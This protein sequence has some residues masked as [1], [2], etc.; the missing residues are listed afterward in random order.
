MG[1]YQADQPAP[2]G[3]RGETSEYVQRYMTAENF[4]L[5]EKL[6]SFAQ[7]RGRTLNELAHA[8]LLAQ[9]MIS[10]VI[11]G[12]T[13][14]EHVQANVAAADWELTSEDLQEIDGILKGGEAAQG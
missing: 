1:K 5:L 12:A 14:P 2:P 11:S 9:P 13:R 10:S 6:A 4:A 7:A 3:S 8:W